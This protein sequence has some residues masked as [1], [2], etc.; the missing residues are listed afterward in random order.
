MAKKTYVG[1]NNI[2]RNVS[3][4]YVGVNGVARRVKKAYVGVNGVAR[5]CYSIMPKIVTFNQGTQAELK[6]MLDAAYDGIIN[7]ADYWSVGDTKTVL[8]PSVSA[9]SMGSDSQ[10]SQN[11][12]IVILYVGGAYNLTNSYRGKTKCQIV[13]GLKNCLSTN[14]GKMY[15]TNDTSSGWGGSPR[16][17][18]LNNQF[19][20]SIT[21]ASC[22]GDSLF[23]QFD[24]RTKKGGTTTV[25]TSADW[26]TLPCNYEVQGEL[27]AWAS[28]QESDVRLTYYLTT[29]N[30]NKANSFNSGWW[31][32]SP[33]NDE[34]TTN[35]NTIS[36]DGRLGI[37]NASGMMGLSPFGV[38]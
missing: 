8:L 29:A 31:L 4:M 9:S 19:K 26:F 10:A 34:T 30:R 24:V 13:V 22:M 11:I 20:T 18:W 35:C 16:R 2:A 12:Q 33:R 25:L 27:P 17:D 1:V 37:Y 38:M 6:A 28:V 32:R 7:L 3:K 36:S 14:G 5:E 15:P 23:K 21:S